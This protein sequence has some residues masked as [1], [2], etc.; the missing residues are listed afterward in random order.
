MMVERLHCRFML[1]SSARLVIPGTEVEI[2]PVE[3]SFAAMVEKENER[4]FVCDEDQVARE[5]RLF[6]HRH[7]VF[8]E[9]LLFKQVLSFKRTAWENFTLVFV[10]CHKSENSWDV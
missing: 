7:I 4:C 9:S 1:L 6:G 2:R 5:T 3:R 8:M 10:T